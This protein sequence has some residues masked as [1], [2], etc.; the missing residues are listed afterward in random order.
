MAGFTPSDLSRLGISGIAGSNVHGVGGADIGSVFRLLQANRASKGVGLPG[1]LIGNALMGNIV[2]GTGNAGNTPAQVQHAPSMPMSTVQQLDPINR[3]QQDLQTGLQ[4]TQSPFGY[5]YYRN[6]A[7]ANPTNYN[8][9]MNYG[10]VTNPY[11]F[12]PDQWTKYGGGWDQSSSKGGINAYIKMTND[13]YSQ[14]Q[15]ALGRAPTQAEVFAATQHGIGATQSAIQGGNTAFF[16]PYT[17]LF[18]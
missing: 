14:L 4:S 5:Q 6:A 13:M 12:T 8:R 10:G 11:S 2:W 7:S 1:G 3:F 15:Q 9:F 17:Q 16:D 18:I